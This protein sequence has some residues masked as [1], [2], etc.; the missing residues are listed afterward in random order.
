MPYGL[1]LNI[2]QHKYQWHRKEVL[3]QIKPALSDVDLFKRVI[4][5]GLVPGIVDRANR[6]T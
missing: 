3:V 5:E 4:N 6:S 1:N 2:N